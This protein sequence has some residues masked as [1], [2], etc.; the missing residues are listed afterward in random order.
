MGA[1]AAECLDFNA[2]TRLNPMHCIAR[3]SLDWRMA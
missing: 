2:T 3:K 1:H